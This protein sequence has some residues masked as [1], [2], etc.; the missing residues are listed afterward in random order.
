MVLTSTSTFSV[1]RE[2]MFSPS[3]L[4]VAR[5]RRGLNKTQLA[6]RIGVDLRSVTGYER[7][8]Y[9][10]SGDTLGRIAVA[11]RFPAA[12]FAGADLHEPTNRTASFR[13]M[14]R[15]AASRREAA[16]A[17][18]ALAFLLNDW[19]EARFALPQPICLI[20][21]RGPGDGRHGLASALVARR[22]ANPQRR[23]SARIQG[24]RVNSMAEDTAEVDAFSLWREATPFVFLNTQKSAER[25]RFDAAH[26]LGHLVLH[27]H[28]ETKRS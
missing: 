1:A 6:E 17:S 8:D 28:D 23:P 25:S 2:A 22:E 7:G 13:S 9:E 26:E 11:L 19:I 5:K 18:G 4:R 16:L 14:A 27:R 3:R 24:V 21:G 20:F 10:P 15:M 12:F